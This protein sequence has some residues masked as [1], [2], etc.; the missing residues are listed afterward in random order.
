VAALIASLALHFAVLE[1]LPSERPPA[2]QRSILI[3]A[4]MEFLAPVAGSGGAPG[5]GSA[6]VAE[7]LP[8]D[9][10][11]ITYQPP[12][13]ESS[14]SR[15]ASKDQ[16]VKKVKPAP[17]KPVRK[18][19]INERLREFQRFFL[20]EDLKGAYGSGSGIGGVGGS[21]TGQNGLYASGAAGDNAISRHIAMI[22]GKIQKNV[23]RNLCQS[24]R[25]EIEFAIILR[26]D[27][28]LER[29]P[30]LLK[31]SGI[32]SCD[33]AI[34]RAILQSLPLPVPNDSA[35]FASLRELNLLFR[36]HDENFGR[37]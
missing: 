33:D 15:D 2:P 7:V 14:P 31:S 20:E 36:P 27:G 19:P 37:D 32:A 6:T 1:W 30:I 23:N 28:Y 18:N 29:A 16:I 12:P 8:D 13:E 21:G 35:T 25:A 34:E 4:S 24:G 17:A 5:S 22:A 10:D 26:P 11:Q 9:T 3:D